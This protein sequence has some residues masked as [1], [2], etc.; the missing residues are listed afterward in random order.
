[1]PDNRDG[2]AFSDPQNPAVL[3]I[4]IAGDRLPEIELSAKQKSPPKST[5]QNFT[6][7]QGRTG[8]LQV[9]VGADFSS[10]TLTL[11]Q[12]RIRYHWRGQSPSQQ[13]ADYYRFFYYIASQFRLPPS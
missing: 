5:Q 13:F 11:I 9:D 10:M 8:K 4:G 12:G 3:I 6:T 7:E 1:M 2:L